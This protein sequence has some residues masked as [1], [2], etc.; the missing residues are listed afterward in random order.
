MRLGAQLATLTVG[1]LAA[2]GIVYLP[3]DD[4]APAPE[5]FVTT[6]AILDAVT[7]TT[8]W[9]PDPIAPA[10]DADQH[11]TETITAAVPAIPDGLG[12]QAPTTTTTLVP[13]SALCGMW[14]VTATVAGWDVDDL[15]T[16]DRVL[17]NESRCISGL[18]SSTGDVGLAQLNVAT[19][20]HLWE[21]DG[22][23]TD[24]VATNPVLNLYYARRVADEAAAIGWCEFEPW[25]GF[26][27]EYC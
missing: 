7:T 2:V 23:T 26:S 11:D 1:T 12:Y 8:V 4:P 5:Q 9:T 15:P 10:L 19:W 16:L 6:A 27:G 13:D 25:H 17:Y 14:W 18:E 21:A 22:H 24:D 3:G 20:A